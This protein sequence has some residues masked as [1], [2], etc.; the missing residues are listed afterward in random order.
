[1]AVVQ[2]TICWHLYDESSIL[3]PNAHDPVDIHAHY[4]LPEVL[5][6]SSVDASG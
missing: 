6:Q 1:M 4:T 3:L 2:S 5:T